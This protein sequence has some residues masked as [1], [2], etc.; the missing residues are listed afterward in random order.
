MPAA[1]WVSGVCVC[2]CVSVSICVR[3]TCEPALTIYVFNIERDSIANKYD[4]L[5][6]RQLT[7][8]SS[9]LGLSWLC[10]SVSNCSF[11]STFS[12]HFISCRRA[13]NPMA[14]NNLCKF[15][16]QC[17]ATHTHPHTHA[18]TQHPYET[19]SSDA[20]DVGLHHAY[21]TDPVHV[22][23]HGQIACK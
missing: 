15:I 6:R 4:K 17:L 14:H 12:C 1:F 18:H 3:C 9:S 16:C 10:G 13:F 2:M 5:T 22:C 11:C 23:G 19:A 20:S 21:A 8:P 7:N